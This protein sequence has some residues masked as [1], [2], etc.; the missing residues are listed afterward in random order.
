M[1]FL[2][3]VWHKGEY[4]IFR[5]SMWFFMFC[6]RLSKFFWVFLGIIFIIRFS[7]RCWQKFKKSYLSRNWYTFCTNLCPPGLSVACSSRL[8][9]NTQTPGEH[10][11]SM[12]DSPPSSS[13][14]GCPPALDTASLVLVNWGWMGNYSF[15]ELSSRKDIFVLVKR[16]K[17]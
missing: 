3:F 14:M 15:S 13:R 10:I 12:S 7:P 2:K 17:I 5:M 16:G 4:E 11:S 6:M 1:I 9:E 8:T